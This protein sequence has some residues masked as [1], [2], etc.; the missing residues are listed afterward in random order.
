MKHSAAYNVGYKLG[1]ADG[2]I[3]DAGLPDGPRA[4]NSGT[5]WLDILLLGVYI[6]QLRM[7]YS[8]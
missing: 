2:K 1:T 6:V 4:C 8:K 5:A 7:E 3:G